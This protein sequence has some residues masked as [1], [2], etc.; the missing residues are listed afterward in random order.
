MNKR[1]YILVFLMLSLY[2]VR[3]VWADGCGAITFGADGIAVDSKGDIWLTHYEDARIGRLQSASSEFTEFLSFAKTSAWVTGPCGKNKTSGCACPL[4]IGFSGIALDEKRGFLWTTSLGSKL[5]RFSLTDRSF[6]EFSLPAQI[7]SRRGPIDMDSGGNLW[8]LVANSTEKGFKDGKLIKVSSDGRMKEFPL[9]VKEFSGWSMAMDSRGRPWLTL[10]SVAEGKDAGLYAF[11]GRKFQPQ[12]L[13]RVGRSV[14]GMVFDSRDNLWF[15]ASEKNV[16][17]KY[18]AGSPETGSV[19]FY[20][21]PTAK[22]FPNQILIDRK[23][24]VWFTEWDGHKIGKLSPDGQISEYPLP[25]EE[26]S[27]VTFALDKDGQIWFSTLFNYNLFR[28]DPETGGIKEYIVPPPANLFSD[29]ASLFSTRK[30][31]SNDVTPG[32]N[33]HPPAPLRHPHG[34]PENPQ[35]AIF[36]RSCNTNCHRWHRVDKAANRT[37]DWIGTVDKM[38]NLNGAKSITETDQKGIIDYL[39]A[40]YTL[41]QETEKQ[42]KADAPCR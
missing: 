29:T 40:N 6:R 33:S 37:M 17:G 36:E 5:V 7:I 12:N 15:T 22:A 42:D 28:L 24:Q 30:V 11:I 10:S 34:Y 18:P 3:P 9:P 35:A 41:K 26:A 19:I 21:V 14:T 20:P 1:I 8:V 31:M 27:P 16:V 13:S 2:W 23:G 32:I 4:P 38:I 25:P 39:N